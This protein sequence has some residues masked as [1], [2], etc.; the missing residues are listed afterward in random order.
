MSDKRI[1]LG[2]SFLQFDWLSNPECVS[3]YVYL[4][5]RASTKSNVVFGEPVKRGQFLVMK[6]NLVRDL[7]I[8]PQKLSTALKRLEKCNLISIGKVRLYYLITLLRYDWYAS[9]ENSQV[10]QS[11]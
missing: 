8:T 2:N 11:S 6:K 5:L 10:E 9:D 7:G 4:L 1:T 3:L